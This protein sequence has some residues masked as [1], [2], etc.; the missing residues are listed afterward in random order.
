M[1]GKSWRFTSS[2]R[3]HVDAES[4]SLSATQT[5]AIAAKKKPN[6]VKNHPDPFYPTVWYLPNVRTICRRLACERNVTIKLETERTTSNRSANKRPFDTI[7]DEDC[8]NFS[9]LAD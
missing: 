3:G 6:R 1:I 7:G 5:L 9:L 4:P 2:T 8:I